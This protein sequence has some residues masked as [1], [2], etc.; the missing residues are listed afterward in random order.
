MQPQIRQAGSSCIRRRI[1]QEAIRLHREIGF[2]KTTVTDIARAASMSPANVYRFFASKQDLE[3]AVVADLFERVSMAATL[4]ARG[5]GSAMERLTAALA[6]ISR[7]HEHRLKNDSKQHELVAAAVCKNWT[8]ALSHADR[9][10]G[11]V[12]AT[13]AD[14]QAS[15]ELRPGS[16]MAMTCCLLESM[17]AYLNPSRI[18]AATVRPA[19]DEMMDFC[20]G[21]LHHVARG[22]SIDLTA[23]VCP[24]AVAQR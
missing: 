18:T 11:L 21:A 10:R 9:I 6:A 7:S 13:I 16:P 5:G 17:D 20:A 8:V 14:G 22:Q 2:K 23:E 3:E 19:F 1:V 15:G 24:N 4:A 12:C